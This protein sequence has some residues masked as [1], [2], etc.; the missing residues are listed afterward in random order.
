MERCRAAGG[1]FI[2]TLSDFIFLTCACT[3]LII[4]IEKKKRECLPMQCGNRQ[5]AI[6]GFIGSTD[7]LDLEQMR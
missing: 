5:S 6:V 7:P 1:L 4:R 3:T 2:K